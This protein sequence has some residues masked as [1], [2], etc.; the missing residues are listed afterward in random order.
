[1]IIIKNRIIPFGNYTTIN[2]FG[3]LFTKYK[4]MVERVK[5]HESIHTEQIK[6]LACVGIIL[7]L[8]LILLFNM[9]FWIIIFGVSLFYIW[10]GIEYVFVRFL[11]KKQN[12]AYHDISL[13]EEAYNNQYNF[14]Y[15][16]TR[17]HFNWFKYIKGKSYKK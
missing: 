5:N 2:I 9:P 15:L 14:N 17:K 10:Y 3:I 13:E 16:K 4:E 8:L 11:H 6:E 7:S 1:M 12:N